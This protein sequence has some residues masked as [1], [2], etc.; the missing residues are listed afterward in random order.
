MRKQPTRT[1]AACRSKDGKWSLVRVVRLP[2]AGGV[3]LDPTGKRAGRGAYLCASDACLTLAFKKGGLAR[4][5]KCKVPA[6]LEAEI[7]DHFKT[8]Q[9]AA[10]A[11]SDPTSE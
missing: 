7:R 3:V 9:P 2:D 4:T 10:P 5:L 8:V 6:A 1:C 11:E